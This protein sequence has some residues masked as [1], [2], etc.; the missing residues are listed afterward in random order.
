MYSGRKGSAMSIGQNTLLET[1]NLLSERSSK[2]ATGISQFQASNIDP[3]NPSMPNFKRVFL[4][5]L[6]ETQFK[7]KSQGLKAGTQNQIK[8]KVFGIKT[9]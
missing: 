1:S 7:D 2:M 9:R 5:Q 3:E 8:E 4:G 6:N